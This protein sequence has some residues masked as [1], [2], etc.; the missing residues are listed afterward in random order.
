M[1]NKWIVRFVFLFFALLPFA[2]FPQIKGVGYTK[3]TLTNYTDGNANDTIYVWTSDE[4][5]KTNGKLKIVPKAGVGPFT[6]DWFYH[7]EVT[8]SWE[9][10]KTHQGNYSEIQDLPTD[11]YRVQVKDKNGNLV[12]CHTAWVWNLNVRVQAQARVLNCSDIN[13]SASVDAESSFVYYNAPPPESIITKNTK[14]TIEFNASHTYISDLAFYLI[15]PASSRKPRVTLSPN[16]GSL[17]PAQ[18]ICNS[19]NDVNKLL[20]SNTSNNALDICGSPAP[21][22]G[23][24]GSYTVNGKTYAIDWT[25]L[26]G[27]NAAQGD[28]SVQI[29]DCIFLDKGFL[30]SAKITFSDLESVC[31]S[32]TSITYDSGVLQSAINDMSCTAA[33][34]SI[35]KVLPLERYRTPLKIEANIDAAWFQDDT[36]VSDNFITTISN[37]ANNDYHF[38]FLSKVYIGNELITQFSYKNDIIVNNAPPLVNDQAFCKSLHASVAHL[39][40]TGTN[41]KWYLNAADVQPLAP[42]STLKTGTYYVSQEINGCE[43]DRVAVKIDITEP[44][45]PFVLDQLFCSPEVLVSDLK[46][47]GQQ[48]QWY[49]SLTGGS[50]LPPT[51]KV[52]AGV[53][54]VTQTLNGCESPTR[55]PVTVKISQTP[56]PTVAMSSF[57]LD[58]QAKLSSLDVIGQNLKFYLQPTDTVALPLDTVLATGSYYVS[59]TINA[60]ESEREEVK[61]IVFPTINWNL[62]PNHAICSGETFRLELPHSDHGVRY[63]WEVLSNGVQ[64]AANGNGN[65]IAHNLQTNLGNTGTVVYKITPTYNNCVGETVEIEV[66][67]HALPKMKVI[68]ENEM[69]C[70]GETVAIKFESDNASVNFKW[71]V[72]NEH[73]SGAISGTGTSISQQLFTRSANGRV[74]YQVIPFIDNCEGDMVEVEV[75]VTPLPELNIPNGAL[76]YDILAGKI[77]SPHVIES[78]FSNADFQFEWYFEG[79]LLKHETGPTLAVLQAGNYL[80][81][82]TNKLGCTT[83]Q[84]I[85][86]IENSSVQSAT[87]ALTNYFRE[88]QTITVTVHGTGDYLYKL[89][90]NPPQ[91]SNVFN[92]VLP[93]V[94]KI[95]VTDQLNCTYL[96]F[97]DIITVHYPNFF[98]PNADGV[99]DYWNIWSLQGKG[100]ATIFIFDRFGQLIKQINPDSEGW[101]GTVNGAPMPSTDYWFVVNYTEGQTPRTFKSHFSLKR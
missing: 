79:K 28:W 15:G 78:G 25:P 82:L 53:Y 8:F 91:K 64:G 4:L 33:S 45:A 84:N 76:C 50:A 88:A 40:A 96:T 2:V 12:E 68:L 70:S 7:D 95:V 65:Q 69:L 35:F 47:D 17:N 60:C 11:G 21:L 32:P 37:A 87:Y 18:H 83:S 5:A 81:Q 31:G 26:Y 61:V 90:D 19:G 13:L 94:H 20:F 9:R 34:A 27:V 44:V 1:I 80:L 97:N 71:T 93:G 41:I 58:Q 72:L 36:K 22:T 49:A 85:Q 38:N 54:Y 48:I 55:T 10:F 89:N 77:L 14:I 52:I 57:C 16:P 101:D 43:S 75:F 63:Q 67:V 29:Y 59:Q 73:V 86:V 56:K 62:T 24:Y 98:T 39:V 92:Q 6:F 46:A 30:E 23:E 100:T 74:V 99:N 42:T 3:K 66:K 51:Q